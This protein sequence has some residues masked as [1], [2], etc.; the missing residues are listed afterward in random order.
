MTLEGKLTIEIGGQPSEV[1]LTQE[2]TTSVKTLDD[3]PVK[4]AT[5][6]APKKP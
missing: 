1:D 3:N 2:Q 5:T 4:A 6:T